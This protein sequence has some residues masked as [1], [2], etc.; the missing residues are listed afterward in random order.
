MGKTIITSKWCIYEL[1]S[2]VF[3]D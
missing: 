1:F 2:W 3:Y